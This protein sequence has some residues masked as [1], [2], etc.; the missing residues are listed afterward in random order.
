[1]N[2]IRIMQLMVIIILIITVSCGGGGKKTEVEVKEDTADL[3]GG[4]SRDLIASLAYL[5]G[6]AETPDEGAFV[7]LVKAIDDVYTE[8]NIIIEIYPFARSMENLLEGRA[9]FHIPTFRN[10]AIPEEE[11]PYR[12]ATESMGTVVLVIYSH[13]D[14]IITKKDINDAI[15][16]GGEFPY[17]IESAGALEGAYLFPIL[18][19]DDLASSFQKL[20]NK[21]IDALVWAQEE[22]DLTLRN[23]KLK[24]IW[25][26]HY[27]DLDDAIVI[28]KGPEGDEMDKILSE[29]L[30]ELKASGR[31]EEL[32]SKIHLPYDDWQPSEMDW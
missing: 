31:Q 11:L 6:L 1:M 24:M 19:T 15:A 2:K 10:P 16:K 29:A 7:D 5:P 30:Q 8:G 32:Y 12:T 20:Q 4:D 22:S 18:N 27:L 28:Q 26:S 9:D 23:L 14:N 21:R 13:I 3:S 25:R 17:V